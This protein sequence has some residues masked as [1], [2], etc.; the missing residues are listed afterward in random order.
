MCFAPWNGP[1]GHLHLFVP[2]L[3]SPRRNDGPSRYLIGTAFG[4]YVAGVGENGSLYLKDG[5]GRNFLAKLEQT[6]KETLDGDVAYTR[7]IIISDALWEGEHFSS[8][9]GSMQASSK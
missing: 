1:P 2:V 5:E 3:R 7:S 4:E 6:H 9:L 8:D